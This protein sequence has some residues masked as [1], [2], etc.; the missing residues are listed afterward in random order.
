MG[1]IYAKEHILISEETMT[2]RI[3]RRKRRRWQA[4]KAPRKERT[5]KL[6][7]IRPSLFG[8]GKRFDSVDGTLATFR[9]SCREAYRHP[10]RGA[11]LQDHLGL[12]CFHPL[13]RRHRQP[14]ESSS[15][16]QPPT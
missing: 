8:E 6:T 5:A 11:F 4:E 16:L 12:A 10:Y 9:P 3:G 15:Q 13:M 1:Q 2:R 14:L 7:R